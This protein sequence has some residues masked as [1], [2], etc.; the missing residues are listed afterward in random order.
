MQA[1]CRAG[2]Y[3][4]RKPTAICTI[5]TDFFSNGNFK[6]NAAIMLLHK[7]KQNEAALLPFKHKA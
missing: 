6:M 3:E 5:Y 2:K 7:A 1:T 4:G